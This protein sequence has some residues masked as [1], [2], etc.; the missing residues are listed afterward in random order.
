MHTKRLSRGFTLI[1]LLVV[2]AIIA[3]LIALLLPAVQQA[4]EAARRSTCKNNMK[5][6]GIA[7][8]NYHDIHKT[9]PPGSF[10][11]GES[12]LTHRSKGSILAR[13]LPQVD[14]VPLYENINFS[15]ANA[16]DYETMKDGSGTTVASKVVPV[17]LC[18]SD[19]HSIRNSGGRAMHNY[20]ASI[21][22]YQTG[23]PT[24][25][26]NCPCNNAF[27]SFI[28]AA[29]GSNGVAGVFFR[30]PNRPTKFR[31]ITDGVSNTIFFGEVRPDCSIHNRNGWLYSNN[32]QGLTSTIY[33]LNYDSCDNSSTDGCARP[34]NWITELGFKS[35]HVG[36]VQFLFGDGTVRFVSENIDHVLYQNLGAKA[37]GIPVTLP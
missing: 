23:G 2:I 27:T 11:V 16:T 12:P 14:Q 34:C 35:S 9:L 25:S 24:G 7:L 30:R 6:L 28:Q 33:P 8:H 29:T 13:L 4:R 36:G 3:I 1:E 18:P 20:A 10:W 5:Q 19:T 26:S 15:A 17:Y 21:G 32:G 31:D 37:N 22:P